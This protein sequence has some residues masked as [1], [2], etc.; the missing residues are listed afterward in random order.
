MKK[1]LLK[2][3]LL[4][5]AFSSIVIASVID[6]IE[7]S[8]NQRISN[9]T[10]FVL[11]NIKT[12]IEYDD[13][14][15]NNSLKDLYQTN[16]FNDI[17]ISFE[18]GVLKIIVVENPII[19][20]IEISGIKKQSLTD[21]ILENLSLK[22]RMSFTEDDF[23]ND[24]TLLKNILQ[25]NGFYFSN[26]TS[27]L[28]KNDQLNSVNIL[29]NVDLGN[30]ARIKKIEF[31]GDKKIKDKKLL[32]VITSEEHKFWK[33]VSNK[34]YLNESLINLDVRLLENYYKN[35]GYYN[36]KVQ[37]SFA[38]YDQKG[39]FKLIF[40]VDS[41]EQF[42]FNNLSLDLPDDYNKSDFNN[43][44]KIFTKLKGEIY[45]LDDFNS[46]LNEIDNIAS[47]KLY[48]FI[49]AKVNTKLIS[50]NKIDLNFTIVESEKFYVER[51]NIIGNYNT[52]EEVI[53]NKLIVDEGDPLNPLLFNKSIDNIKSLGIFKT[54]NSKKKVDQIQI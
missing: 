14:D 4:Y 10:I 8:G 48:D 22:Q 49:D 44:E 17:K 23:K 18:K 51:I 11:G 28:D 27:S 19:E 53:R 37:N 35:Q 45:S 33:F 3:L 6:K 42:V 32:E 1:I 30:R 41:G 54:V 9:E 39:F 24:L 47:S 40:N 7:I 20:K 2:I 13:D 25:T 12:G 36:A 34:V 15:L 52:I 16:F 50:N 46:I 5:F 21:S 26:V 43:V 29:I 31:I 38:E